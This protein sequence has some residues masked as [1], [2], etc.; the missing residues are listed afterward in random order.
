MVMINNMISYEPF[1][2]T[3]EDRQITTYALI[4]KYGIS[5]GTIH[6][7]KH[8]FWLSTRTIDDL[9]KIVKCNVQDVMVFVDEDDLDSDIPVE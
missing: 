6:R 8:N 5:K 9:C 1:W 2:H 7:M 3:L 4:T